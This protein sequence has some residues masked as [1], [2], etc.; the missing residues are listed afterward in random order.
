MKQ[1]RYTEAE[2][3]VVIKYISQSPQNIAIACENAAIELGRSAS[4]VRNRWSTKLRHGKP[5]MALASASG[6]RLTNAKTIY[7]PSGNKLSAAMRMDVVRS[8]IDKMTRDEKQ[9]TVNYILNL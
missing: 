4:S 2:D 1:P 3:A 8:S 7:R 6:Y 5:V 9:Q